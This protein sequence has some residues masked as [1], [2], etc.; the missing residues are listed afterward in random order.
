MTLFL[1]G[2]IEA[3]VYFVQRKRVELEGL[4]VEEDRY[5]GL[6]EA[7]YEQITLGSTNSLV[8]ENIEKE[9]H[10][11]PKESWFEEIRIDDGADCDEVEAAMSDGRI[12]RLNP[13]L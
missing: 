6:A 5:T 9:P 12:S 8:N 10:P 4:I 7:A 13:F 3:E 1:G 11:N 2:F